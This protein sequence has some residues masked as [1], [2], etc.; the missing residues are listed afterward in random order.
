M[1]AW[2]DLSEHQVSLNVYNSPDGKRLILR[3]LASISQIPPEITELGFKQRG[4]IY[5]RGDLQF[6]LPQIRKFFPK[7]VSRECTMSEIFYRPEQTSAAVDAIERYQWQRNR[8]GGQAFGN[9]QEV[10]LLTEALFQQYV[11]PKL[12]P[13]Y[14]DSLSAYQVRHP[15]VTHCALVQVGG[16]GEWQ[17]GAMGSIDACR[18]HPEN[19]SWVKR[20]DEFFSQDATDFGNRADDDNT[21]P[22]YRDG[23]TIPVAGDEVVD[24]RGGFAGS[25]V[26]LYGKVVSRRGA[27]RVQIT[28]TAGFFGESASKSTE[29]LSDGWTIK[30][31]EHPHARQLRQSRERDEQWQKDNEALKVDLRARAE[32]SKAEGFSHLDMID[33]PVGSRIENIDDG[34]TGTIVEYFELG[35]AQEPV[36]V[37][38]DEPAGSS[39]VTIGNK[40]YRYRYRVIGTVPVDT[41]E[42]AVTLED[43]AAD[44]ASTVVENAPPRAPWHVARAVFI[45][46][47]TF[48]INA[49][50][51]PGRVVFDDIEYLAPEMSS[52]KKAKEEVH[53]RMVTDAL[54]GKSV[55]VF[56]PSLPTFEVMLD[57]PSLVYQ[58]N[59][60]AEKNVSRLL[61]QLGVATKLLAGE[62]GYLKIENPPYMDLV[63]E[64]LPDPGGDRLY[65]THYFRSNGDSI[66]DAEMVFNIRKNGTLRLAETATQDPIRGGEL[67]GRDVSFANMF[68][69]NLVDQKFGE[70][71]VL[72][73]REER[74]AIDVEDDVVDIAQ[75]A[76]AAVITTQAVEDYVV[77]Q[78]HHAIT[79][80]NPVPE[81]RKVVSEVESTDYSIENIL[82]AHPAVTNR[83]AD[84]ESHRQ[85]VEAGKSVDNGRIRK[86]VIGT[87]EIPTFTE[88]A[89]AAAAAQLAA[90]D[91]TA[92]SPVPELQKVNVYGESD[93]IAA[94]RD[95]VIAIARR[96]HFTEKGSR[97]YADEASRGELSTFQREAGTPELVAAA[98]RLHEA[99]LANAA[100]A[101]DFADALNAELAN[102]EDQ[103]A[104]DFAFRVRGFS[105]GLV[106]VAH[107]HNL[108]VRT[109]EQ[110]ALHVVTVTRLETGQFKAHHGS[111]ESFPTTLLAA[112]RWSSNYLDDLLEVDRKTQ[113]KTTEC[114]QR[115][116]QSQCR[117]IKVYVDGFRQFLTTGLP[118]DRKVLMES[119]RPFTTSDEEQTTTI[120]APK[121]LSSG[122]ISGF[123]LPDDATLELSG[124]NTLRISAAG[125]T[126]EIRATEPAPGFDDERP[127]IQREYERNAPLS[128][129]GALASASAWLKDNQAWEAK[130]AS[131]P[132]DG[133]HQVAALADQ[134][135]MYLHEAMPTHHDGCAR[136]MH[137]TFAVAIMDKHVDYLM[138]W[139]ARGRG[140]NDLSKK[141]FTKATGCKLP[142]TIRDITATLYAWAGFTP[143]QASTREAEKEAA[144]K[145]RLQ[146]RRIDD[147]LKW[148]GNTL[149]N[150]RVNHDGEIKT[151]KQF[152][153]EILDQGY[154]HIRKYKAGAVDR[155]ALV[156]PEIQRSYLIKGKMV[157]Y[158]RAVLAKRDEDN[159]LDLEQEEARPAQRP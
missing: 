93:E 37:F 58:L 52:P 88:D 79:R 117:E 25:P 130:K 135:A 1:P 21:R 150:S 113:E 47:A 128:F 91:P 120:Y 84:V 23:R 50:D 122:P 140:Q 155:Y 110:H 68:S 126:C 39:G 9:R 55:N 141:F 147:D 46:E 38:D 41:V 116:H 63:I 24:V 153:D 145:A 5:E 11:K 51:G 125:Y 43:P 65:L 73:P 94:A 22:Q 77:E 44:P 16:A 2:V 146:A 76:P 124:E 54:Y 70:G 17:F 32:A 34:R 85:F 71:K 59:Q 3:P 105:D 156:N 35:D 13:D 74:A 148:H 143:G 95:E 127:W 61:A 158:A 129:V 101:K 60:R 157:D 80:L 144:H 97:E 99:C 139:I 138:D 100:L 115:D 154:T 18:P 123:T 64:R 6:S 136:E 112:V 109:S 89:A 121:F 107:N 108:E 42:E 75:Q 67:R 118:L 96:E 133:G 102:E 152:M 159:R 45:E 40:E 90:A 119:I 14:S 33:P 12:R 56:P 82:Q 131:Y 114:A 92:T 62:D 28:D 72:W 106:L 137:R 30:N 8:A 10:R 83:H 103:A 53:A 78:I 27:L 57:Y 134:Y 149:S 104:T 132:D 7:A 19:P 48:L 20:V 81:A 142:S 49:A 15:D 66:M 31:E 29:P 98:D 69:K 36:V 4:E 111:A 86:R 26:H 151:T 87:R